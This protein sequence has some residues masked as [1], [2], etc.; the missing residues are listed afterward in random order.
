[1]ATI[2]ATEVATGPTRP[3]A[4][5]HRRLEARR[6]ARSRLGRREG[7][8]ANLRVALFAVALAVGWLASAGRLGWGWIALPIAGFV[9]LVVAHA[10]LKAAIRRAERA[11]AYYERGLDRVEDRWPGR[12]EDGARFADDGH[13]FAADLDLFGPGSLFQRVNAARTL[14]GEST[15]AAWLKAPQADPAT[16]RGRQGA[17][18]DMAA[19]LDLREDLDGL[20]DDVRD[21]LD[22]EALVAWGEAPPHLPGTS[23]RLAVRVLAL[24]AAPAFALWAF[25]LGVEA[26]WFPPIVL[27]ERDFD[28]LGPS[29]FLLVAVV[30][31][32]LWL[33][34]HKG[35]GR[36]LGPVDRRAADLDRL[37]G[38]LHRLEGEEFAADVLRRA[39]DG[40]AVEGERPSRQIARLARIVR[41]IDS[42]RNPI[43]GPFAAIVMAG[44][45]LAFEVEGWRLASGR[46]IA[47][48][49]DAVGTF[50][51]YASLGAYA[52]ENPDDVAPEFVEGEALFDAEALGHPLIPKGR[53]VRNAIRLGDGLR[54]LV[55][56]G[57]NMSGKSTML[58][59]VGVNAVLAMV[60]APARAARLRL[61]SLNLGATLRVQDSLQAGTSRFYAELTRLRQVVGLAG[62]EPPLLFLLDEI[63]HGTNSDDRRVGAEG[64][65]RGLIDR[66]AI[67]LVTT[68]DLA[69][70]TIADQLSPRA[71]NVH[72]SDHFEDDRLVFDY[73][74][75]PGVVEHSNAL[76]LMRAVGLMRVPVR[77]RKPGYAALLGS[78]RGLYEN[79]GDGKPAPRN[80]AKIDGDRCSNSPACGGPR[81]K[82][83]S[84]RPRKGLNRHRSAPLGS[85]PGPG[86]DPP[87]G[88]LRLEVLNNI[89][90][91]L[92]AGPIGGI[93]TIRV[94]SSGWPG[95]RSRR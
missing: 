78:I 95:R 86:T 21:G 14:A 91:A 34:L 74:M 80:L 68:H 7:L 73:T 12:G 79:C 71:A 89:G 11:A 66:G 9:G 43:V 5:Y 46:A 39:R 76:A 55:V 20:G 61:S 57:S 16:I 69:L 81:R 40:I 50:D 41:R 83:R 42:L 6:A 59:T 28:G 29:P 63:F 75:R 82:G 45:R 94:V 13:P 87:Q 23:A 60:G 56:S 88:E 10:R 37:A 2:E 27:G 32:A 22:A 54:V 3:A 93:T 17:V 85:V 58:R 31:I 1:M 44:T 30:E 15:L 51:A 90:P 52:F 38:L 47:G 70:A 33:S 77:G 53:A 49:I 35:I 25:R 62:G 26:D 72:F 48:W 8:V 84:A 65:V 36:V 64:V 67:G 24:L 4:E 19:R 92:W 18:A